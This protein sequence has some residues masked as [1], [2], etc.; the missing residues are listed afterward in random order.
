M[1]GQTG[2]ASIGVIIRYF[3]IVDILINFMGKINVKRSARMEK[4]IDLINSLKFPTLDFKGDSNTTSTA[5]QPTL[6]ST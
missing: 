3:K 4:W 2:I 6:N 1:L 5:V